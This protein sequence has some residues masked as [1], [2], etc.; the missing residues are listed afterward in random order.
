M[1]RIYTILA[2]C[3]IVLQGYIVMAQDSTSAL[4]PI[5]NRIGL[6]ALIAES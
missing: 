4:I 3:I 1:K 2:V 6:H 5:P